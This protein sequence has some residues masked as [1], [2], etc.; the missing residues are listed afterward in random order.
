MVIPS[1]AKSG[2]VAPQ[3]EKPTT[4][5]REHTLIDIRKDGISPKTKTPKP[6]DDNTVRRARKII[7]C[8]P[9]ECGKFR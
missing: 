3:A 6:C 7:I 2:K 1:I 9:P 8:R 4:A 5:Q